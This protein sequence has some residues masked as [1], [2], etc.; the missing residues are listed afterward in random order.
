MPDQFPRQVILKVAQRRAQQCLE[1]LRVEAHL[2]IRVVAIIQHDH[3]D[4]E[5]HL[6]QSLSRHVRNVLLVS[7]EHVLQLLHLREV[8]VVEG[9]VD[10]LPSVDLI[11]GRTELLLDLQRLQEAVLVE[12]RDRLEAI[13]SALLQPLMRPRLHVETLAHVG[14]LL[15]KSVVCSCHLA[16]EIVK[17]SVLLGELLEVA[18]QAISESFIADDLVHLLQEGSALAVRDTI[19]H[20]VSLSCRLDQALHRMRALEHVSRDALLLSVH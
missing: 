8:V 11:A 12:L 18:V 1:T 14:G 17:D 5:R 19:E 9:D 3:L 15:A 6:A 10:D 20:L 16:N 2:G 13:D 7:Y 4:R